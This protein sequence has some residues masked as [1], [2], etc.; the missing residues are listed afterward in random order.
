MPSRALLP[1]ALPGLSAAWVLGLLLGLHAPVPP[2]SLALL[3][4]AAALLGLL[5]AWRRWPFFLPILA[6]IALLGALRAENVAQSLEGSLTPFL[7]AGQVTVQGKVETDPQQAGAEYQF[8][9]QVTDIR[10]GPGQ[11]S[12]QG[13]V[14]VT[15]RPSPEM[16]L[17]RQEPWVR[18]GDILSLRG[19]LETPPTFADFDYRDYLARQG[20][21][22]V[23]RPTYVRLVEPEKGLMPLAWLYRA[24]HALARGLQRTLPE[25]Q[26]SLG[27]A[28]L[29]GLRRELPP[30]LREAFQRSGTAHLLAVSGLHVA[31]VLG[32]LEALA[33]AILGR[34]AWALLVPLVGIWAYAVLTGLAPPVARAA[35]M[36]STYLAARALGR[37]G[38]SLPALALAAA[39]MA[40]LDPSVLG[41]VSFQLSFAAVA[42][43]ALLGPPL[44]RWLRRWW[45]AGA[46]EGTPLA[47][48]LGLLSSAMAAGAAA[49]LATLPL[50]AFY[51]HRVSLVGVPATLL[52][53]PALTPALAL[54]AVAG[55]LGLAFAPAG[56]AAGWL[57]WPFLA[58][59]A[60]LPPAFAA[61]PGTSLEMGPLAPA[62]VLGYY[63]VLLLALGGAGTVVTIGRAFQR[64]YSRPWM[65]FR[66]AAPALAVAV[67][68]LWA[69]ALTFPAPY[70]RITALEG[71]GVIIRGPRGSQALIGGGRDPLPTTQAL[72]ERMPFWD[73]SLDLV[74]ATDTPSSAA[75]AEVVRRYRVAAA[76]A[77]PEASSGPGYTAWRQALAS[78]RVPTSVGTALRP[79][80]EVR[81]SDGV[82]VQVLDVEPSPALLI[83]YGSQRFL[84]AG[85]GDIA[86]YLRNFQPDVVWVKALGVLSA[87][88]DT[89]AKLVVLT[90]EAAPGDVETTRASLGVGALRSTAGRGSVEVTSDGRR[91]WVQ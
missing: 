40:G 18:Y 36:G 29:L 52:A 81:T 10:A 70:L 32:L 56:L 19:R 4:L 28:L 89:R 64:S 57:A 3:A 1:W 37:P 88:G 44:Q 11:Q 75:L 35:I 77:P 38:S 16:L 66:V 82:L 7:D 23:I 22:A 84:V 43:L 2:T 20:V 73:H 50:T 39:A 60:W 58:Y 72:G 47:T 65:P 91:L 49:T 55:A 85:S 34:R 27:Q 83:T 69:A 25:P 31:I 17:T 63:L 8:R 90:S 12:A 24:R 14:L 78:R 5:L 53:L 62:A 54:G 80:L 6:A 13:R 33:V 86:T 15:A 59:L 71:G 21:E 61:V 76:L 26:A 45:P 9:F 74:V 41:D 46:V 67:A 51:F 42:G 79:G 87:A 68:V 48:S 30:D